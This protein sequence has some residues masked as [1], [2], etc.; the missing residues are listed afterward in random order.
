[1][2]ILDCSS[3]NSGESSLDAIDQSIFNGFEYA[4]KSVRA[5]QQEI[6][7]REAHEGREEEKAGFIDSKSGRTVRIVVSSD[8]DS[9]P[10][11][12]VRQDE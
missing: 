12:T 10:P 3:S 7:N 11:V 2:N 5:L 9:Q 4:D 1:M 6:A 8:S